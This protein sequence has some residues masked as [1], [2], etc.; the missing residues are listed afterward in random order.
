MMNEYREL[1]LASYAMWVGDYTGALRFYTKILQSEKPLDT[2]S[3]YRIDFDLAIIDTI[4]KR[5]ELTNTHIGRLE[6][7]FRNV[8]ETVVRIRDRTE[9]SLE[10]MQSSTITQF[11]ASRQFDREKI[12]NMLKEYFPHKKGALALFISPRYARILLRNAIRNAEKGKVPRVLEEGIFKYTL[13]S[14]LY[15]AIGRAYSTMELE[16][17]KLHQFEPIRILM[18]NPNVYYV[19][20]ENLRTIAGIH[21]EGL[22][23]CNYLVQNSQDTLGTSR[24]RTF[25]HNLSKAFSG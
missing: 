7:A 3:L 8:E 6:E 24:I 25:L 21:R 2:L 4:L 23:L 19:E 18:K 22:V 14:E 16:L 15:R 5:H 9:Q 12:D 20:D 17:E 1:L 13:S 10:Q 11:L